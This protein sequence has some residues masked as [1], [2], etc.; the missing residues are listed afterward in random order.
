VKEEFGVH[1]FGPNADS[2]RSMAIGSMLYD[3]VNE[4]AIDAQLAPYSSSEIYLL[5]QHLSKVN[6]GDLLLL[7]RGYPSIWL[8]F[9]LFAKG[10]EFTM[11]MKTDWWLQVKV[12]TES[13]EKQAIVEFTL[14]KK[15]KAKLADYPELVDA[16][17][18]CRLVKVELEDGKIEVLC[19][20]LN[21]TGKYKHEE[22]KAL[23]HLRWNEEEA[24]KLLKNRIE[25]E[26][27][28]GKTARAVKQDFHAKIFLLS[29]T[30]I[31][32]HPIAE[33]VKQDFNIAK[34]LKH[35]QQIN[36]TNAIATA[37]DILPALFVM[38]KKVKTAFEAFDDIVYNTREIIRPNR[39]I[40]R[41]HRQKKRYAS[42]YKRL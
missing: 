16:T 40:E 37:I 38:N 14:P 6:K 26:D 39:S 34:G 15:D 2:E 28:S 22:F 20:S 1:H 4:V 19:T 18:A 33:Q 9:L 36:R 21:D 30:A 29:L 5:E 23:Y 12:F 25:L 3:V 35:D 13:D 27:F 11:R 17:I 7:D 41:K 32:A 24:Y 31:Y 42:A 8:I 10:I